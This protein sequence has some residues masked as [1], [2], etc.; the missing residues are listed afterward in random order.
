MIEVVDYDPAWPSTFAVLD[1][2]Y[3]KAL[4]C[5]RGRRW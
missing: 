5:E 3:R 1:A 2:C 4:V